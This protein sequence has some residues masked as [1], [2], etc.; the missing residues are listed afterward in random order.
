MEGDLPGH[1][2]SSILQGA[3]QLVV[4]GG[5][6]TSSEGDHNRLTINIHQGVKRHRD[7]RPESL[8]TRRQGLRS[9]R[10]GRMVSRDSYDTQ[11]EESKEKQGSN[12]VRRGDNTS[13]RGMQSVAQTD[14]VRGFL[15]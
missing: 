12:A 13:V 8:Y 4:S 15:S 6:F 7:D 11:R 1:F 9:P 3:S 5:E 14:R 2:G 10:R